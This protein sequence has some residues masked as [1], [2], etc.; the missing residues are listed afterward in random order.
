MMILTLI[1]RIVAIAIAVFAITAFVVTVY[2][3]ILSIHEEIMN[4][5]KPD[6]NGEVSNT[7]E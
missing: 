6:D 4:P 2:L 3:I 5:A 1:S 7:N